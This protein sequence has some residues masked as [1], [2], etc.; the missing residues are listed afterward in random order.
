VTDAERQQ[1]RNDVIE[2][3]CSWLES[4]IAQVDHNSE[5]FLSCTA[6]VRG[7][8]NKKTA[9]APEPD[10]KLEGQRYPLSHKP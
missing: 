2:E 8:R 9:V 5:T 4:C 3:M 7:L 10:L 6:M 1:V